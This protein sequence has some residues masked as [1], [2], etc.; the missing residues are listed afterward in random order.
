MK[1]IFLFAVSF[2][3][4]LVSHGQSPVSFYETKTILHQTAYGIKDPESGDLEF[5][6]RDDKKY[7]IVEWSI[8]LNSEK[9]TGFIERKV[10]GGE[11]DI[12]KV[13]AYELSQQ[14]SGD[15]YVN[16]LYM[17]CIKA[18]TGEKCSIVMMPD[19]AYGGLDGVLIGVYSNLNR[20]VRYYS[21]R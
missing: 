18:S 13:T 16:V 2:L 17:E 14:E 10:K 19:T 20:N 8:T 21:I 7:L 1:K 12:F 3:F 4:L 9:N 5:I 6:K 15:T 11:K